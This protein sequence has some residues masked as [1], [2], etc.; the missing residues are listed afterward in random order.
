[1]AEN[2]T[3]TV[4]PASEGSVCTICWQ[5]KNVQYRSY[6]RASSRSN[7]TF[8]FNCVKLQN[9]HSSIQALSTARTRKYVRRV[10]DA[11]HW[12]CS[13]IHLPLKHAKLLDTQSMGT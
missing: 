7:F 11:C 3:E 2:T 12:T 9:S 5:E 6:A 1:M 10:L 8:E 13:S 4:P